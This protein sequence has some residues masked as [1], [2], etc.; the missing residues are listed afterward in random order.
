MPRCVLP[1]L[2]LL[3]AVLSDGQ[4]AHALAF[5]LVLVAIPAV[6]VAA[7]LFFGELAEGSGDSDAGALYVGLTSIALVLL[8]VGAAV[9]SNAVQHEAV[10]A[11]GV[12]TAV[13]ALGLLTLQIAVG[14]WL[15]L[16]R[17]GLVTVVRGRTSD[18][19]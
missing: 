16:T 1:A 9:R 8:V 19:A 17:D 4:G 14:M 6:A 5:Y 10:P 12:S 2:L 18:V 3:G 13:G 7:L 15:R 11:L